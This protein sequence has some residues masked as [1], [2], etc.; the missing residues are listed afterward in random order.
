MYSRVKIIRKIGITFAAR[1]FKKSDMKLNLTVNAMSLYSIGMEEK[2]QR[3]VDFT[4]THIKELFNKENAGDEMGMVLPS[5]DRF[6]EVPNL[7]VIWGLVAAFRYDYNDP[8]PRNQFRLLRTFLGEKLAGPLTFVPW[9]KFIPPFNWIYKNI[10]V[11]MASFR[12]SLKDV[13]STQK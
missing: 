6:F 5:A 1:A 13:I 7:N 8:R 11:S 3:E 10:I 12:T 2:I 9:L 4:V